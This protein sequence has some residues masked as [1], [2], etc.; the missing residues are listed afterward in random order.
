MLRLLKSMRWLSE[1]IISGQRRLYVL[2]KPSCEVCIRLLKS[3]L[4]VFFF[5]NGV[6]Q[7]GKLG[8]LSNILQWIRDTYTCESSPGR[9]EGKKGTK[10][11]TN[12]ETRELECPC[13]P[14]FFN[15]VLLGIKDS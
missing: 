5:I 7:T 4:D 1:A 3:A 14:T 2:L 10:S 11:L 13:S 12:L 9:G 8:V 15:F 6:T